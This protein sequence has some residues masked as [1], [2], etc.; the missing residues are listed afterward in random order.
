M[1]FHGSAVN[2]PPKKTLE[3]PR[4]RSLFFIPAEVQSVE[5]NRITIHV[6]KPILFK[7]EGNFALQLAQGIIDNSYFLE[8]REIKLNETRVRVE[9]VMGNNVLLEPLEKFPA[10]APGEKV[11]IFLEKKVIAIRDFEVI[12]GGTKDASPYLQEDITSALVN[13]GQ[14]NVVERHKL[15]SI[16]EELKLSQMGL[17]DSSRAKQVGKMLGADLI[18]TA[19]LAFVGE[20]CNANIRM[21]NTETGLITAAFNKK[22]PLGLKA[23][24]H[25]EARNIDGSFEHEAGEMA[26]WLLGR[27]LNMEIGIGGYQDVYV[28]KTQGANGTKRS[29][30]MN[31]KLGS[32]RVE[33]FKQE[34]IQ[35]GIRNL[36]KRDLSDIRESIF[37][38]RLQGK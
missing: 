33:R 29:L 37:S 38:S 30:A 27:K 6:E 24:V 11:K 16:L 8:G 15:Q 25:K 22:G 35:A 18:L 10:I 2:S 36:L 34:F 23:E 7:S 4:E 20:E 17:I 9:R 3:P 32:G 31:F 13:S 14:F 12:L 26:G 5:R 28:D 21:I 19:T 1:P